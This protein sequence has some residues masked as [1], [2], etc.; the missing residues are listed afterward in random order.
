M[1]KRK[2]KKTPMRRDAGLVQ[3]PIKD[4]HGLLLGVLQFHPG[5]EIAERCCRCSSMVKEAVAP[6]IGVSI[7][8]DGTPAAGS[9]TEEIAVL[10]Q[11]ERQILELFDYVF[12]GNVSSAF[13]SETRPFAA[14]GGTF[15]C[16]KV[17][18]ALDTYLSAHPPA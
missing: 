9:T 10:E 11:A 15:Y 1:Q 5:P 8:P 2:H 18:E 17:L 6:L 14:V 12:D 16:T 13:F 7:N 4:T 3:V